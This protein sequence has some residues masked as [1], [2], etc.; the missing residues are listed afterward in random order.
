MEECTRTYVW[1]RPEDSGVGN[2]T[3]KPGVR[4]AVVK[5]VEMRVR[6]HHLKQREKMTRF[7]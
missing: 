5:E 7:S 2:A 6:S 1:V 3:S 4:H